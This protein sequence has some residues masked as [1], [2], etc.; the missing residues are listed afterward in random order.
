ML[1]LCLLS[2]LP[3]LGLAEV[4]SRSQQSASDTR[5]CGTFS[6]HLIY[7]SAANRSGYPQAHLLLELMPSRY[8]DLLWVSAG[9]RLTGMALVAYDGKNLLRPAPGDDPGLYYFIPAVARTFRL[10]IERSIDLVLVSVLLLG[11]TAGFAGCLF[12][13][14][15]VAGKV[16]AFFALLLLTAIAYRTGDIY[17]FEF[18]TSVALLPWILYLIRRKAS[19]HWT[20][21]MWIL[22]FGLICGTSS[23]IRFGSSAPA[24]TMLAILLLFSSCATVQRKGAWVIVLLVGFLIPR[25]YLRQLLIRSDTFLQHNVVG[26]RAGQTSRVFGHFTY[27]GLGFLSNPYVPGGVCDEVA[28][29]KV[30]SISPGAAYMSSDYDRILRREV[31]SIAKQH[32][33]IVAFTILAKLGIIVGLIILFANVGLLFAFRYRLRW[34]IELA[35]WTAFAISSAPLIWMAPL[36]MYCLGVISLA[37]VYGIVSLDHGIAVRKLAPSPLLLAR[38]KDDRV[39]ALVK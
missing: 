9:Y 26:Y 11:F 21:Y 2:V 39:P 3:S 24:L 15:S 29:E 13:L 38:Y 28:K 34:D 4:D 16:I 19:S 18:S 20:F 27:E 5:P 17:V 14:E 31:I 30:Q 7:D 36:P 22:T 32:P 1:V 33:T 25:V 6:D 23:L 35:F 10:G 8:R 37:V 12:V